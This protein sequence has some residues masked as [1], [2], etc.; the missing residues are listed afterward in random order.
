MNKIIT[1]K[2]H[3]ADDN[4]KI[5]RL[6]GVFSFIVSKEFKP[7]ENSRIFEG[8]AILYIIDYIEKHENSR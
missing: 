8:F 6:H 2:K 5:Y 4:N 3:H 7:F 1:A